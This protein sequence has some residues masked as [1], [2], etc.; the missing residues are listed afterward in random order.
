MKSVT[1]VILLLIFAALIYGG[2]DRFT[3]IAQRTNKN[4]VGCT[5]HSTQSDNSVTVQIIG[6]DTLVR[7]QSAQYE[8]KLTGGPA[9]QGGFN[10]ASFLGSLNP[11][12]NSSK[13]LQSELVHTSAKSFSGGS[14]SWNFNFTAANQVYKDTLYSV[15]NSV[16][17]DGSNSSLDRWNFGQKFVVTVIDQPS[18]VDDK[19]TLL[20]NFTL[21]QNYPNPFNPGTIISYSIPKGTFVTLKIYDVIGNEVATLV[22]ETKSAG[23]YDINFN[24]SELSNGVYLYQLKTNEFTSTRKMILMK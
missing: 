12:D 16:N 1:T 19:N 22:N 9:V 7:G 13:I 5:C 20:K 14:V 8:I 15:A 21:Q 2:I 4:G 11:V 24:A 10:V 17:G 18:N 3:G 6:P 23:K